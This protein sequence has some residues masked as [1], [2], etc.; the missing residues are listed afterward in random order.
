MKP[1][2]L[3][4]WR[5]LPVR[6]HDLHNQ[7]RDRKRLRS[8][9]HCRTIP[10]GFLCRSRFELQ[11]QFIHLAAQ[12]FGRRLNNKPGVLATI[13]RTPGAITMTEPLNRFS[14][15]VKGGKPKRVISGLVNR[16]H[17]EAALWSS[18]ITHANGK[19]TRISDGKQLTS[20]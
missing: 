1:R 19:A 14:E 4:R 15:F 10:L 16:R 6:R 20:E 5:S 17:S 13:E 2:L 9:Q 7:I 11:I 8:G 18:N 3:Q 12:I